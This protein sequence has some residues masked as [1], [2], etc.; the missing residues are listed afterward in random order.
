M[1]RLFDGIPLVIS[2]AFYI[3]RDAVRSSPGLSEW[4]LFRE[5]GRAFTRY[6]IGQVLNAL[7]ATRQVDEI[8]A[9]KGPRYYPAFRP[10]LAFEHAKRLAL[11]EV[12]C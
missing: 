5:V 7:V 4:G 8:C 12:G 6:A 3:V 11:V 10:G 2:P 9:P 1:R